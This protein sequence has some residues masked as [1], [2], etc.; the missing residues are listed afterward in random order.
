MPLIAVLSNYVSGVLLHSSHQKINGC[1]WMGFDKVAWS[2]MNPFEDVEKYHSISV[3]PTSENMTVRLLASTC[4]L[5]LRIYSK[6]EASHTD[7][8]GFYVCKLEQENNSLH[9]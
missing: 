2:C 6:K 8:G 1:Q 9:S 5:I 3:N 7:W 4:C